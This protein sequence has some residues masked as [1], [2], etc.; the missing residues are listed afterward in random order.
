LQLS[1]NDKGDEEEGGGYYELHQYEGIAEPGVAFS[2]RVCQGADGQKRF[3][4][5]QVK[6]GIGAGYYSHDQ[7]EEQQSGI[8]AGDEGDG[9]CQGGAGGRLIKEEDNLYESAGQEHG[10]GAE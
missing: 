9:A 3:E 7:G 4:G 1:V 2:R 10:Q 8:M 6:G 5:G